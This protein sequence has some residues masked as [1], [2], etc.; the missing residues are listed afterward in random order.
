MKK[1]AASLIIAMSTLSI[2]SEPMA[3]P[4]AGAFNVAG[5]SHGVTCQP[6]QS[7]PAPGPAV[8][9]TAPNPAPAPDIARTGLSS[10]V[11]IILM[12]V[13]LAFSGLFLFRVFRRKGTPDSP[14][15]SDLPEPPLPPA[16]TP[17]IGARVLPAD[18]DQAAFIDHAK[19]SFIR[20]QAA[21]DKA[22]INDLREFTTPAVFAELS[23]QL[24]ARGEVADVTDVVTIEA[25]VLGI[26]TVDKHYLASIKFVGLIKSAPSADAAPFA[27]VWNMSKPVDGSAGWVLAG[28]QQ[29]S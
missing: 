28:I 2:V 24:Q 13:L 12:L 16:S 19:S 11:S 21:W 1:Y 23:T 20:M 27:E 3:R 15:S 4:L 25:E 6:A 5:P 9:A 10:P 18:F 26:D 17:D 8:T 7:V 22:D 14:S 29:L